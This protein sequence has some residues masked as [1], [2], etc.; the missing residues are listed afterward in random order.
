M[1]FSD[2]TESKFEFESIIFPKGK[3]Q[4]T[5]DFENGFCDW[6]NQPID[7]AANWAVGVAS[8]GPSAGANGSGRAMG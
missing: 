3:K 6:A 5:C 8:G 1:P 2:I 7:D 4:F